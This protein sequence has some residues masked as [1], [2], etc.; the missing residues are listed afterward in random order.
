MNVLSWTDAD[1]HFEPD[2]NV[3]GKR[4]F[5]W[6]NVESPSWG[7]AW[8]VLPP[9][10]VSTPHAH[11]EDEIFFIVEGSGKIRVGAEARNI[12]FGDTIYIRN[13]SEHELT[14][15]GAGRLVYVSVWWLPSRTNDAVKV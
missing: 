7:S 6:P 9:G 15:D 1:L 2:Y 11:S 12:A 13:E 3:L 8:V 4:L 14:N 5:P 10:Q